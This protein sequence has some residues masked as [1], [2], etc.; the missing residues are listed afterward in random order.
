MSNFET[1]ILNHILKLDLGCGIRNR[2]QPAEE[3]I[4]VDVLKIEGIDLVC[5]F[6]KLPFPDES[7]SEIYSGDSLEH[8]APYDLEEILRE[9][10]R[11]LKVGGKFTGSTPNL[12]STM[13][14]YAKG[15]LSFNDAF[16]ALYG[17]NEHI[18]QHHFQTFTAA[19][20]THELE[21][22]GFGYVDLS[23]SPGS[24]D[25]NDAWWLC[26]TCYKIENKNLFV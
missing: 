10:L 6:R 23:D 18:Y 16:G 9:W 3:W 19:T 24:K 14:R 8:I 11:V 20:L 7:I 21:K 26:F 4:H 2:K 5:D 17:S 22:A 15:E 13:M 25:P 12:H 1:K